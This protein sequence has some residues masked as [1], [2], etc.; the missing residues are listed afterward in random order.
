MVSEDMLDGEVHVKITSQ[1]Q[2]SNR[3]IQDVIFVEQFMRNV[4]VRPSEV[5]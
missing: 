1:S 5:A 3:L 2:G 4:D